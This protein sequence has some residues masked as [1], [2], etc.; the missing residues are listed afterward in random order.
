VSDDKCFPEGTEIPYRGA[1]PPASMEVIGT[2][3]P[4]FIEL[5]FDDSFLSKP[6][7]LYEG[8]KT[9]EETVEELGIETNEIE[10]EGPVSDD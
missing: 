6:D 3:A 7:V 4:H 1:A 5:P 8:G 9:L 2:A 10:L